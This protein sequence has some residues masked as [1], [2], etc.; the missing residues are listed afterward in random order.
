MIEG[1]TLSI[2]FFT[3]F[4]VNIVFLLIL[5]RL[6]HYRKASHRDSL[7]GFLLFGNGI[8]LVTSL[9]HN[10]EM[11]MGFA[12]GLFAV[13]SMLRYRTETLSI[14]DMAYLFVSI[15]IALMSAV[16]P[17]N[18][19]ELILVN[20]LVCIVAI[21]CES[22]F[23]ATKVLDKSI[24]YEKIDLIVPSRMQELKEDLQRRTGLHIDRIEV[25]NI[26]FLRDTAVLKVYY[27]AFSN[28]DHHEK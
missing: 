8:F 27:S 21:F 5:L 3:R 13:F 23:L 24:V 11:S 15:A 20:G 22:T 17:L 25:G 14:G 16:S 18:I 26:D 28:E 10:I 4:L 1:G 19:F 6:I 9:L 12:F 7:S 2:D